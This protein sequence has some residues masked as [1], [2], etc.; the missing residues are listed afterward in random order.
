MTNSGDALIIFVM[1]THS[2]ILVS[3]TMYARY[4]IEIGVVHASV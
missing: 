2:W 4:G 1:F 3:T